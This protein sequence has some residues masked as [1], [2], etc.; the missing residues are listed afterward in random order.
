MLYDLKRSTFLFY[1]LFFMALCTA[2]SAQ[3]PTLGADLSYVNTILANGGQYLDAAGNKVEPFTFFSEKS[4]DMVRLRLWHTP[5]NITDYCG[6][7]ITSNNLDDVLSAAEK[8]Q[9]AGMDLMLAI[10]YGDY[11]NDP[12]KQKMPEAWM[13][14]THEFLLDSIYAYTYQVLEKMYAQGTSPAIVGIGNETTWGFIDATSSTNGWQWPQDAEKFNTAFEAVDDF[15]ANHGLNLKKA[16]HFTESTAEWLAGLFDDKGIR[17]FDVI[18]ISYYP[19]YSPDTDLEELGSMINRLHSTYQKEVMI[20]ETGF[21]WKIN[22]WVDNYN[23]ILNHNGNVLEYPATPEG[24]RDYLNDLA[25]KVQD[26]N[27]S[28]VFYW[29]PAYISS[30]MCTR[31]GQGSPYENVCL[32]DYRTGNTALPAFDFFSACDDVK[33]SK[34]QDSEV[35]IFPNPVTQGQLSLKTGG[36]EHSYTIYNSFG[37]VQSAGYISEDEQNFPIGNLE[38]GTYFIELKD[39]KENILST[40]KLIVISH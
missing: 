12:G 4:C 36:K 35:L 10:H 17:N 39:K 8:T 7:P 32:F 40:Q 26:N 15:N 33:T 9:T 1:L 14:L 2:G 20:F 19:N 25:Q 31:W 34:Y 23:N 3:C 27:G 16:V 21:V 6:N 37:I 28:G 24:Q 13:G 22:G 18:G 11:F 30:D 38:T 5:E 29:E